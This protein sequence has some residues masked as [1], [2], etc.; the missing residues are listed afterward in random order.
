MEPNSVAIIDCR[1]LDLRELPTSEW[2][3]LLTS[4][5]ELAYPL[6]DK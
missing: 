5:A 2:R 1:R 6:M 4:L 3:G